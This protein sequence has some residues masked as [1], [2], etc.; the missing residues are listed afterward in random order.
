MTF[1]A[2]VTGNAPSGTVS[3]TDSGA[4]IGCA[5]VPLSA[6]T[7]QCS[8]S[9]LAAGTHTIVASYG[10]DANNMVSSGMV[11]QVVNP[12]GGGGP[13][14]TT[15]T[16]VSS[17]NPAAS[18]ASVVFTATVTGNAPTGSVAF[19]DG[20]ANISNCAVVNLTG[21]SGNSRTA[22]CTTST[23][24]VGTH[25]IVARYSGNATNA[26]S[27]SAAISQ[28]ITG[29]PAVVAPKVAFTLS[30]T[31][32]IAPQTVTITATAT[33]TGGVIANVALYVN[34]A[35]SPPDDRAVHVHHRR[36]A[37]RHALDLC[38]G[39]GHEGC[40]HVDADADCQGNLRSAARGHARTRTCGAC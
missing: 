28:S 2:S 1:T 35:K 24:T 23:L 20:V 15:T 32:I 8:T 26:A 17:A 9:G 38:D 25:S 39:D 7:A 40:T 36:I 4:S 37:G 14:A 18:G 19:T 22:A 10:G 3:F 6:G 21:G 11:S 16:L 27:T 29:T 30:N 34:G 31:L 5:A 13:G 33:E 12:G